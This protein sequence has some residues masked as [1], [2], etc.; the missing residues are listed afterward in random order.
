MPARIERKF[1]ERRGWLIT[2]AAA[3]A[4]VLVGAG[5]WLWSTG[6]TRAAHA[7]VLRVAQHS[8]AL[9]DRQ[10][11][12]IIEL[13]HAHGEQSRM[14]STL[15]L[16]GGEKYSLR[17]PGALGEVWVGSNGRQG[18]LVPSIG[19]VITNDNPRYPA[20]WSQAQNTPIPNLQLADLLDLMA[21]RFSLSLLPSERLP[22]RP[23]HACQRISGRCNI[24]DEIRGGGPQ[25]IELWAHP[26]TGAA[27][28]IVLVW[29]LSPDEVGRTRIEVE[30][31]SED[32]VDDSWYEAETHRRDRSKAP[33]LTAPPSG[34]SG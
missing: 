26:V 10:Y 27:E 12:V 7:A 29:L 8:R 14:H 34:S 4:A 21:E 28:R 18:W 31:L 24:R 6:S 17:H 2:S 1:I 22:S 9:H 15:Y 23:D 20:R 32:P 33:S 5:V 25:Q 19:P 11:H 16:R 30:L 3:A 13:N